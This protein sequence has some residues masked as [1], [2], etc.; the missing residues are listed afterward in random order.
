MS[1]VTVELPDELAR[2]LERVVKS[3]WFADENEAVRT[4]LRELFS[5]NRYA[6]QERQKLNDIAWALAAK[7]DRR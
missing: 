2:E 4:A 5:T 1:T 6:L 3:G 7:R